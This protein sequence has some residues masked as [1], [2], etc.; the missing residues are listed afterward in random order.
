MLTRTLLLHAKQLE[1]VA[2]IQLVFSIPISHRKPKAQWASL[3]CCSEARPMLY[4][5]GLKSSS[6]SSRKSIFLTSVSM[7]GFRRGTKNC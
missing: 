5:T 6:Q 3:F 1:S 4:L 7:K 2:I